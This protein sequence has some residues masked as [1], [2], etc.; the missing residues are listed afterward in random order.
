[1]QVGR[2]RFVDR[3]AV[4][5]MAEVFVAVAQGTGGFEKPVVI[6]RLLPM[7]ARTEQFQQMFLD[8][9][10]IM[11][12]LQHGNI[13]QI[14]DMGT[15]DGMPFLTLEYV[16]GK[17]LRTVTDRVRQRE[18]G[19]T[20]PHEL[21]AHIAS[22]VCRALDYAHRKTDDDGS[23][24]NIV[25]RDVNPANIFLS[26]EGGV[27]LGDFGLAS[28]RLNLQE[29]DA[30]VIKGKVS[31]LSPE[32][33][34][35]REI[36]H[37]SDI[38]AL[39]TTLYEL[40]CG[41]R[42]FDAPTDADVVLRIREGSFTPP[43]EMVPG[44][45]PQ[46]E[47][48]VLRAMQLDPEERFPTANHMRDALLRYLHQLSTVPGDRE[49][50]AFLG[51]L[52]AAERRSQS[53]LIRLAPMGL[54]PPTMTSVSHQSGR[55]E[56]QGAASRSPVP[57]PPPIPASP[58]TP[59]RSTRDG[60]AR[61]ETARAATQ[62]RTTPRRATSRWGRVVVLGA[63]LGVLGATAAALYAALGGS[64]AAL[65]VSSAPDGA[66]VLLDGQPTGQR[67][68][69][70]LQGLALG[71]DHWVTLRHPER[72]EARRRFR[73]DREGRFA[74][75]FTLLRRKQRLIVESVPV[76]SD[77]LLDGELRG[78][79]PITL[80]LV[81]GKKYQ[82]QLRKTG[83]QPKTIQHHAD[84]AATRL[85]IELEPE[86]EPAPEKVVRPAHRA[87]APVATGVLE[88][89][90]GVRARVTVNGRVM[91]TTPGFR[92]VL[93][94]GV[95]DVVV[96]PEGTRIRHQARIA[97]RRGETHRVRLTPAP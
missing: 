12:N 77:V 66:E 90:T 14:M 84:Q 58:P 48:V 61:D 51:A 68:P 52:F 49:L 46:L 11:L 86:P 94:V 1:M 36:D 57:G 33:A 42:P 74:F 97:V 95:H 41:E 19:G 10:R 56:F 32:Q 71:Q 9:A 38:F 27:K 20:M 78:Q 82:V 85:R 30:G 28:A 39:G 35:G 80:S 31:Y 7:L 26:H 3:L 93:P 50:A 60:S 89:V 6:K 59:D 22:E 63:L 47:A 76:A 67:T 18:P 54:L 87:A 53:A 92:V 44:F 65:A 16:D 45:D 25:H 15:M 73:F 29:S 75:Q 21:V 69:A 24:L 40:C 64:T 2:Y 72:V 43:C 81:Q 37:R 55:S 13:V 70:L 34:Y 8:E 4:G 17:D 91:G 83:Y 79:A 5:G 88:V 23:P 62:P 96:S